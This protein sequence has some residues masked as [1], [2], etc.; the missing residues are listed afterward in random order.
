MKLFINQQYLMK[1]YLMVVFTLF[2]LSCEEER[3]I[4]YPV[5]E[6]VTQQITDPFLQIKTS[7]IGFQAGTPSYDLEFNV[8]NGLKNVSQVNVYSTFTDATTGQTSNEV[9]LKSYPVTGSTRNILTDELT[10][11]DLKAGLTLNGTP[12]PDN[13]TTLAVGSGWKFRFEGVRPSGET[14]HLPGAV[15]VAVLSRFAGIYEVKKAE[16]WRIGVLRN[17]VTGPWIGEHIFIGSVD[18][19]TFSHNDWWGPFAWT[20]ESFHFDVDLTTN[21]ITVPILVDGALFAGN[22]AL[23]CATDAGD[24][25]RVK[26]GSSN[27]LI[28]DDVTG[29]HKIILSYGYFVDGSGAREFYQELEKVVQ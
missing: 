7:V 10:Y 25:S 9:L 19:N 22:R 6:A 23:S 18:E 5:S 12:L 26:C 29:R 13:Q 11:A 4:E 14:V 17:D 2:A 24:L 3:E 1:R 15:N 20:G 16:Y 28:P 8:I 27:I 21:K